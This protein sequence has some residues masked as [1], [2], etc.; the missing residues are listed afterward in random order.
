MAR[1]IAYGSSTTYGLWGSKQVAG[2]V[3]Q[4]K[5]SMMDACQGQSEERF[6]HVY[7]RGR[8]GETIGQTVYSLEHDSSMTFVSQKGRT[9]GAFMLGGYDHVITKDSRP[10]PVTTRVRFLADLGR[11][12]EICTRFGVI[13]VFL[14]LPPL[15]DTKTQEIYEKTGELFLDDDRRE[16][17]AMVRQ[18]AEQNNYPFIEVYDALGGKDMSKRDFTAYDGLHSNGQAHTVIHNLLASQV[19]LIL[20][21]PNPFHPIAL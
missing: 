1:V 20:S 8:P 5:Y 13:A 10:D 18:S 12:G 7:N 3:E 21:E 16:Y 2:Y 14:G 6:V 4:L 15:D 19:Q 11:I 17:E 9:I